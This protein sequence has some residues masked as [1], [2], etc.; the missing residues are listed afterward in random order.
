MIGGMARA[1]LACKGTC[2]RPERLRKDNSAAS[3][4]RSVPRWGRARVPGLDAMD[5]RR[6]ES[7][8]VGRLRKEFHELLPQ[9]E[10]GVHFLL[11]RFD[12]PVAALISHSDYLEFSELARQDAL[13]K[14]V[15]QGKGYDPASLTVEQYLALLA[16][17]VR[18][19]A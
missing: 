12:K 15:L 7:I 1:D 14:A 18:E 16:R 2:K 13:A 3:G 10:A 17:H 4:C 6:V 8:G 11:L 19:E 5:L 9:V